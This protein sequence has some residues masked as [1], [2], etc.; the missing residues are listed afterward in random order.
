MDLVIHSGLPVSGRLRFPA[1]DAT[2]VRHP[3]YPLTKPNAP[4]LSRHLAELRE[5]EESGLLSNYGPM[6][7]RFERDVDAVLFG[8]RGCSLTVSSATVGL[9]LAL[10]AAT[11][12]RPRRANHVLMPAFTFAAAAHAVLWAGLTPFLV[13]SD[14]DDWSA[15]A[16]AEEEA[17]D[18]LGDRVAA[19]MPYAT[20]GRG[21]D[22]DR[23]DRM[24]DRRTIPIVIDAASSIGT[25]DT[26]GLNFGAGCRHLVV[27]SLHATKAFG[28]GEG[29]LVHSGDAA[30]VAQLRSMGNFGFDGERA[31]SMPGLNAKMSEVAALA[32]LTKLPGLDACADH[33]AAMANAYRAELRDWQVQGG[34][35]T[36]RAFQFMP[37]L[38]PPDIAMHRAEIQRRM[39]DLGVRTGQYFSPHLA[40]QPYFRDTCE[41]GEL[42]VADDLSRRIVALPMFDTLEIDDVIEICA[43]ARKACAEVVGTTKDPQR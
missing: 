32:A 21:I 27:F 22:L 8:G 3:R 25:V 7:D 20:F 14:P 18:R 26:N 12:R 6:T 23:Y 24:A 30:A 39:L 31:A 1:P 13:D 16:A 33:R 42:P 4:R 10:K 11:W 29:G 43:V 40:E 38:L 37:M 15:S 28:I 34:D 19:V 9:M 36:R 35:E 5:I 17:L 2:Q 41:R